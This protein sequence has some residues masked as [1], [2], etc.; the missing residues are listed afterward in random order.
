M[1]PRSRRKGVNG[2]RVSFRNSEKY[3]GGQMAKRLMTT[4][5]LTIVAVSVLSVGPT[6]AQSAG[7]GGGSFANAFLIPTIVCNAGVFDL[8]PTPSLTCSKNG[9][10][11]KVLYGNIKTPSAANKN[12]LVMVTLE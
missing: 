7:S 11:P 4:M 9:G 1:F 3:Q 6:F 5:G 8:V 2:T 12:V 10:G